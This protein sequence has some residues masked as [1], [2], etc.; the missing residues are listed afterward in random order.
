MKN[1]AYMRSLIKKKGNEIYSSHHISSKDT[2]STIILACY[3]CNKSGFSNKTKFR[4]YL[5]TKHFIDFP[6]LK[7]GR[8]A[9]HTT[10]QKSALTEYKKTE[11]NRET[12]AQMLFRIESIPLE[13]SFYDMYSE[14]KLCT[15]YS[16]ESLHDIHNILAMSSYVKLLQKRKYVELSAEY[17][18]LLNYDWTFYPHMKYFI[19]QLLAGSIINNA[20]NNETIMVN[21]IEVYGRKKSVDIHREPFRNKKHNAIPTSLPPPCKTSYSDVYPTTLNSK[22][23]PTLVI[24]TQTFN[25]LV[26]PSIRLDQMTKPS[27]GGVTTSFQLIGV[28]PLLTNIYL[29]KDSVE[30]AKSLA[31]TINATPVSN[32]NIMNQLQQLSTKFDEPSSYYLCRASGPITKSC[33]CYPYLIYTLYD[34]DR[35]R[36]PGSN[37]FA[38]IGTSVLKNG[39][40]ASLKK[41]L[42]D[43]CISGTVGKAKSL[44]IDI[45]ALF[46]DGGIGDSNF[47]KSKTE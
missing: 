27:V 9:V 37:I 12:Q 21:T 19:A 22:D 30:K 32:I 39:D 46:V 14:E 42:V 4:R 16:F 3:L 23:G 7:S 28:D 18:D 15:N 45:N 29:D 36:N 17:S 44:L 24:G 47:G 38:N 20:I 33:Q 11:V 43:E 34:F 40:K 6:S 8:P 5:K 13:R 31:E 2:S 1:E 41:I 25:A 10:G 35:G 26:T